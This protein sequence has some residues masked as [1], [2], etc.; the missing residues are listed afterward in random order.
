MISQQRP[1]LILRAEIGLRL[2]R[3]QRDLP[4]VIAER[5]RDVDHG[6]LLI[7]PEGQ[8]VA[9]GPPP[10]HPAVDHDPQHVEGVAEQRD[11]ECATG[12]A[13]AAVAGERV[14]GPDRPRLA[15]IEVAREDGDA[16]G[17]LLQARDLPAVPYV[18]E[19]GVALAAGAQD[20]LHRRLVDVVEPGALHGAE[21]RGGEADAHEF[22]AVVCD[23]AQRALRVHDLQHLLVEP[24][25]LED[26]HRPVVDRD[27][28][29]AR[30]DLGIA[31]DRDGAQTARG[32]RVRGD[33]PRGAVADDH[34]IGVVAS[35]RGIGHH[36]A[37]D[38]RRSAAL[39]FGRLRRDQK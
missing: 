7:G 39:R 28:A 1:D 12:R 3:P 2:V 35:V 36:V 18:H 10:L 25:L 32:Q 15:R 9:I 38:L 24:E 20:R 6:T 21:G 14:A 11:V 29:G 16:V 30:I 23:P 19:V 26:P 5:Q 37:P 33:H 4:A 8:V 22:G 17:I 13:A 31:L 27:G 34:R